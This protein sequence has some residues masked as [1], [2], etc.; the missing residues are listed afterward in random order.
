MVLVAHG[1][2]GRL[3]EQPVALPLGDVL[4]LMDVVAWVVSLELVESRHGEL[5][6]QLLALAGAFAGV[7]P[8]GLVIGLPLGIGLLHLHKLQQY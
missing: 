3:R 4:L 5:L 8:V 6:L 1:K 7:L 2:P